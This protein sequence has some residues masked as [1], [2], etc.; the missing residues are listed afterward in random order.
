MPVCRTCG[1]AHLDSEAHACEATA[2]GA[3]LYFGVGHTRR[4]SLMMFGAVAGAIWAIVPLVLLDM[5]HPVGQAITVFV[6]GVMTGIVMSQLL[7]ITLA[8]RGRPA[9]LLAG[10]FAYPVAAFVFGMLISIV[11][12]L[13]KGTLGVTYRVMRDGFAP[14]ESGVGLAV[15]ATFWPFALVLVPIAVWTTHQLKNIVDMKAAE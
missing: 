11:Q 15:A 9:T 10:V 5:F 7:A 2:N 14:I 13:A 8:G 12:W 1:V 3:A 6:A 4:V